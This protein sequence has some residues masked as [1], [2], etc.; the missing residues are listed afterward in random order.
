[1]DGTNQL[2]KKHASR[3]PVNRRMFKNKP[4]LHIGY[5][6]GDPLYK[7]NSFRLSRE[8]NK[9][10]IS[11]VMPRYVSENRPTD[12]MR[13]YGSA[14]QAHKKMKGSSKDAPH[15]R[16]ANANSDDELI[17][18]IRSFG[19]VVAKTCTLLLDQV[20]KDPPIDGIQQ[21]DLTMR[22]DQNLAELRNEQRIYQAALW[23]VL[24]LQRPEKQYDTEEASIK[25]Q[26]IASLVRGW[27]LQWRRERKAC[28][29]APLWKVRSGT[30]ERLDALSKL[31][32]D[33][34]LL[35]QVDARIAVCQL[36]NVFPALVFPNP[37]E[38]HSYL[39]YGIRPLLYALLR[40]EFVN[41]FD[42]AVCANP[43]CREFFEVDRAGKQYCSSECS[44][45]H[46]Q[47]EY[48]Q[49]RGKTRRDKRKG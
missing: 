15:I 34:F 31:H 35:P 25:I 41:T 29:Q 48:W 33:V 21:V 26:K 13:Q 9:I 36:L 6:W 49:T 45:K 38:M 37:L 23:L 20:E 5:Q 14:R 22:A 46:R 10:T 19:P 17:E 16:F 30:I 47:R 42:A 3:R 28:G 43:Q 12:L 4:Q 11:A 24:E 40:R 8:G 39:R 18:F 32:S 44:R 2:A 27:P 7:E 1:M